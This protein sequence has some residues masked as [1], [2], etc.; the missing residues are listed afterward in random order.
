M[1]KSIAVVCAAFVALSVNA[2]ER[3]T[4]TGTVEFN[5]TFSQL[6]LGSVVTIEFDVPDPADLIN[7]FPE[8][9]LPNATGS[10]IGW[11]G[12]DA[13]ASLFTSGGGEVVEIIY[14]GLDASL[15]SLTFIGLPDSAPV[16]RVQVSFTDPFVFPNLTGFPFDLELA[17]YEFATIS[18]IVAGATS[19]IAFVDSIIKA[20]INNCTA[21]VNGDGMLTPADFNAWV[22]NFNAGC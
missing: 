8:Y 3:W 16:D 13:Q 4:I 18:V 14:D 9:G 22:L 21:D 7:P 1:Y 12:T 20:P 10:G 19:P 5:S 6:P 2:D 11:S 15:G 17:D